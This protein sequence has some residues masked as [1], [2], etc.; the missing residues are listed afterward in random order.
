MRLMATYYVYN[1]PYSDDSNI[2]PY[3]EDHKVQFVSS[4]DHMCHR[5]SRYGACTLSIGAYALE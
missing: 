5:C 4:I 3:Y 1:V 2:A